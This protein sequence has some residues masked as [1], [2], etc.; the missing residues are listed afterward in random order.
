MVREVMEKLQK[1]GVILQNDASLAPLIRI[2]L[3]KSRRLLKY[4]V[5]V[6]LGQG[7]AFLGLVMTQQLPIV[8]SALLFSW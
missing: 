7:M 4:L 6:I 3:G 2:Q 8:R 1:V 5:Q